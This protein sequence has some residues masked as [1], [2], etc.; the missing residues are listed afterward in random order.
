M[1]RVSVA[2]IA[3]ALL[4]S[5]TTKADVILN[6]FA[7]QGTDLIELTNDGSTS[8]DISSLWFC[9]RFSYARLDSLS[10]VGGG[11]LIL[12]PGEF[13]VFSG[14]GL[15]DTSSDVGLYS[16]NSFGS[17]AAMLDFAQYGASGI[18]REGV[19][20]SA[21][22][23][24]AGDFIGTPASATQSLAFD[25]AGDTSND[26]FVSDPAT[27]GSVNQVPEP[28]SLGLLAMF[29]ATLVVRRRR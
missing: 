9:A 11:D 16:T 25:G 2:A 1:L 19:A 13:V 21:G 7:Y 22:I 10:I 12:D 3:L 18:G 29:G 17:A 23:W 4:F 24:T 26:W 5:S 15:D 27:F 20:V 8:E 6:E 28:A 14:F